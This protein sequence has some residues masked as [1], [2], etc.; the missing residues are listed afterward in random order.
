MKIAFRG[1]RRFVT[2]ISLADI[3]FLILIFEILFM[4]VIEK[5]RVDLPAFRF[6]QKTAF[7]HTMTVIVV[8]GNRFLVEDGETDYEGLQAALLERRG[9]DALVVNVFAD[10]SIE[11]AVVDRVLGLC[12][13]AGI[14]HALLEAVTR[15]E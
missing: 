7:P 9:D 12:Q 5:E 15:H 11:Y 6:S 2:F 4:S 8:D 10:K 13:E 14:T 1:T 3:S